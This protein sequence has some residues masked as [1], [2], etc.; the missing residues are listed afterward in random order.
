VKA[1]KIRE[2]LQAGVLNIQEIAKEVGTTENY[3]KD[4]RYDLQ[5]AMAN[6]TG[7]RSFQKKWRKTHNA[8]RND[9]RRKNYEKGG[10]DNFN[11]CKRYTNDEKKL[12]LL[13][14][15]CDRELAIFLGRTVCAIQ[16]ERCRILSGKERSFISKYCQK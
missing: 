7:Y 12:I 15:G 2:L 8:K 16:I 4:L 1:D 14:K 9:D 6:K 3:V 10:R 11:H 13:F 5:Y